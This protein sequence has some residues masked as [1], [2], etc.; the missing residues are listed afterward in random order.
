MQKSAK[1]QSRLQEEIYVIFS[2]EMTAAYPNTTPK[3]KIALYIIFKGCTCSAVF[4]IV[5]Y[6]KAI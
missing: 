1:Y 3:H 4:I 6:G 5:T 2:F